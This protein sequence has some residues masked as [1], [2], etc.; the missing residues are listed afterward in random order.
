MIAITK[1]LRQYAE[2]HFGVKADAS[3]GE[4][5][6]AVGKALLNRKLTNK[7]LLEL[8]TS[9]DDPKP[10]K[11]KKP[12]EQPVDREADELAF[13]KRMRRELKRMGIRSEKSPLVSPHAVFSKGLQIRVKEAADLYT[14]DRKDAF[15]PEFT[16]RMKKTPHAY[17]G[18]RAKLGSRELSH[19]SELDKAI[20]GAYIKFCVNK[21]MNAHEVPRNLKMKEH[22]N[23]L[24][25]YALHNEK[26]SG[27]IGGDDADY[28]A[29][30][31]KREKLSERQIKALLDDTVSGGVEI[32]PIAFDDAIIL[33]PVLYGELFP[34]VN[35][36]PIARGRRVKGGA[37]QL[38]TFTSGTSE[39]SAIQPFNTSGFISAFDTAIFA[40]AAAMQIGLDFEEDTPTD[41]GGQVVELYG[42]K[43][44]EYLD[45]VIAVGDGVTEPLGFFNS[46][47]T[48]N[49]NSDNGLG[50]GPTVSDYESL[51]FGVA[52]QFRTEPGA[53]TAFVANDTSYRRARS[54]AVGPTDER[55]VFGMDHAA[56]MLLDRPYKVQNDI[57]NNKVAFINLKRYRM[58]RRLGLTVRVETAGATLALSNTKLLVLRMR[59]GGQLETGGAVAV[60]TDM[61]V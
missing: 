53:I 49:I 31:V 1:R 32:A 13:R 5:R 10:K 25:L 54:I 6:R 47:G 8:T 37:M 36:K 38:P 7:Q 3:E 35:V 26:W 22:D 61:Q 12:D 42:L 11:K 50:G 18:E 52:K 20:A 51:M 16:G 43:A 59:W 46:S 15:Y 2:K 34:F 57:S 29:E 33:L 4:V 30:R 9:P 28:G 40:P 48:T 24:M 58:Y 14:K 44:L 41:I 39:G 27:M 23:E 19:P 45:R 55:R 17:A 21:T 56:Y 60:S